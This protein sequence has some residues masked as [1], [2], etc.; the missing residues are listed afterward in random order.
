MRSELAP[1]ATTDVSL[2]ATLRHPLDGYKPIAGQAG[3][4]KSDASSNPSH[5]STP[6]A[7]QRVW[8]SADPPPPPEL[9]RVVDELDDDADEVLPDASKAETL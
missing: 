2:A 1:D 3:C 9:G 4:V 6:G 7:E 8:K 5:T